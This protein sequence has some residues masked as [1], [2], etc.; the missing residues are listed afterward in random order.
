MNI[1]V[2]IYMYINIY[3]YVGG[4]E[5][6]HFRKYTSMGSIVSSSSSAFRSFYE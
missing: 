4:G 1:C 5:Q 2:Y 3:I 6:T